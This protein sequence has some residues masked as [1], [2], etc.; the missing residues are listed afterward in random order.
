[1]ITDFLHTSDSMP[2][3]PLHSSVPTSRCSTYQ[4]ES[5]NMI[6]VL[7]AV[8]AVQELAQPLVVVV[9]VK[10]PVE[11]VVAE[12]AT[13]VAVLVAQLAPVFASLLHTFAV[14]TAVHALH[15]QVPLEHP[16]SILNQKTS[17]TTVLLL[18][19]EDHQSPPSSLPYQY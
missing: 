8:V 3:A 15:N 7:V 13:V 4:A 6:A 12:L 18:S 5:P 1:M 16:F 11:L 2:S 9:I 14:P 19:H 17:G 10:S